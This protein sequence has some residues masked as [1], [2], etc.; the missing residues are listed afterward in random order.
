MYIDQEDHTIVS[1]FGADF[2]GKGATVLNISP[3]GAVSKLAVG[4]GLSDVIGVAGDA[5]GRVF[6]SNWNSGQ[7]L[8]VTG[9]EI[10]PLVSIN[11]KVNQI[12]YSRGYLYIPAPQLHKILRVNVNNGK[13][14]TI[15]G[16]GKA[17]SADGPGKTATFNR[18][19]SCDL[20][21][22]GNSLYVYD[23]NT[24]HVRKISLTD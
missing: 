22:D 10:K 5:N 20:S 2:S 6:A 21:P 9:G 8:E 24:G 7:I 16:T 13:I 17:G 4:F 19:N 11:S 18:P 14:E 15:A 23:R 1:L 3:D 12:E